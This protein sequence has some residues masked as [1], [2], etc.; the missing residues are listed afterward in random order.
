[1]IDLDMIQE[2]GPEVDG[3]AS[4]L[5]VYEQRLNVLLG[6][7]WPD[8]LVHCS[9]VMRF[10]C[11]CFYPLSYGAWPV[12]TDVCV[13][14]NLRRL[15]VTY[16]DTMALN[17]MEQGII[18][19]VSGGATSPARLARLLE[20]QKSIQIRC[21]KGFKENS[22]FLG[23]DTQKRIVGAVDALLSY[24]AVVRYRCVLKLPS[25]EET[26]WSGTGVWTLKD[27]MRCAQGESGVLP[28]TQRPMQLS[29]K[30][31]DSWAHQLR[32]LQSL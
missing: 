20:T 32:L 26:D 2:I 1:M 24:M 13:L 21:A 10:L 18:R 3:L 9:K 14:T 27:K 12:V 19:E 29:D 8:K 25:Y 15:A 30:N 7:K 23:S 5:E 22:A 11:K 17:A 4:M 16:L 6:V 28:L 31:I